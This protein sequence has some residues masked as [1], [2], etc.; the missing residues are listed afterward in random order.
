MTVWKSNDDMEVQWRCGFVMTL[1]IQL[2]SLLY[3]YI[4]LPKRI[5]F[6]EVLY[7]GVV[8]IKTCFV[9]PIEGAVYII[10]KLMLYI[11]SSVCST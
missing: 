1:S 11:C 3:K 6:E 4:D 9:Q 5:A 10:K 8:D 2:M 7:I